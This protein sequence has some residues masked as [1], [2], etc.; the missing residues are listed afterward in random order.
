MPRKVLWNKG[1]TAKYSG[2]ST[3]LSFSFE[4]VNFI[5]RK[6]L[7]TG[8]FCSQGFSSYPQNIVRERV[9]RKVFRDKGCSLGF[10]PESEFLLQVDSRCGVHHVIVRLLL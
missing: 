4:A 10:M 8:D 6:P 5:S 3:Y 2:I 9:T 7:D 1:L